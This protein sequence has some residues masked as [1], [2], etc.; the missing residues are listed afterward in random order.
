MSCCAIF[1]PLMMTGLFAYFTGKDAPFIFPG[2]PFIVGALLTMTSA[3]IAYKNY[4][5]N[6]LMQEPTEGLELNAVPNQ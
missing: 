4:R 5:K 2:A 6:K 1:G 3:I